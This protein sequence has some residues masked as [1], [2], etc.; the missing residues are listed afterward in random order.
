MYLPKESM[1][2]VVPRHWCA[3]KLCH[4]FTRR[5]LCLEVFYHNY[6]TRVAKSDHYA[7]V[8]NT[9]CEITSYGVQFLPYNCS[10]NAC[11]YPFS[12]I[13]VKITVVKQ[14]SYVFSRRSLLKR[15]T[16][17]KVSGFIRC[18]NCAVMFLVLRLLVCVCVRDQVCM[19]LSRIRCVW[20]VNI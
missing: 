5:W 14:E 13:G 16:V 2:V 20:K 1:A 7:G 8:L 10:A 9:L 11:V 18:N 19:C 17:V 3:L 15:W 12:R 4:L 6:T